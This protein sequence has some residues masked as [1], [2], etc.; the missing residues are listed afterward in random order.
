SGT[1]SAQLEGV[2]WQATELGAVRADLRLDDGRGRL[3]VDVPDLSARLDA[4]GN[5][6]AGS[7]LRGTLSLAQTGLARFAHLLP[8]PLGDGTLS[9]QIA[10]G[11]SGSGA[12]RRLTVQAS[13]V[14]L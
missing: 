11:L 3:Q 12:A 14:S 6:A 10:L 5:V 7:D 1:G 8:E 13:G 9:A 2:V 4:E